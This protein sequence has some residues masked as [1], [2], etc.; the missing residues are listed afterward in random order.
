MTIK[1]F[2]E[3][4]ILYST[5]F[6]LQ[7]HENLRHTTIFLNYYTFS[8]SSIDGIVYHSALHSD[9]FAV[10]SVIEVAMPM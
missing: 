8:C 1:E 10:Y 2:F 4:R 6:P 5:F 7:Q 9:A 3:H